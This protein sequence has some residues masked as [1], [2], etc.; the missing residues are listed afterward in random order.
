MFTTVR[1]IKKYY[2]IIENAFVGA[3]FINGSFKWMTTGQEV[4]TNLWVPDQPSDNDKCV[5]IWKGFNGID[6]T[7]IEREK[8]VLCEKVR[9][10]KDCH[11]ISINIL[12]YSLN[13]E[14]KYIDHEKQ[15]QWKKYGRCADDWNGV[16]TQ[17]DELVLILLK[18]DQTRH[19]DKHQN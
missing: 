2:F 12:I 13:S 6:D 19:T 11:Y 9:S 16:S 17:D 8:T 5:Q 10:L 7:D 4:D 1:K 18:S 15:I 3:H 14:L